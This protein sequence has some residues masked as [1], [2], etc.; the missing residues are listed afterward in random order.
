MTGLLWSGE[1]NPRDL[2]GRV[3]REANRRKAEADQA[4][5]VARIREEGLPGADEVMTRP[6]IDAAVASGQYA[7]GQQIGLT[8]HGQPVVLLDGGAVVTDARVHTRR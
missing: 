4:A 8:P 5:E 1:A 3:G 7:E 2:T 6:Q